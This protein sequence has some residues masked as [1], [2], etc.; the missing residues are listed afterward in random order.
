MA[1]GG[2]VPRL[3]RRHPNL[4]ADTSAGSGNNALTRDPAFA[5]EF[6][7]EFQDKLMF[8]TDSCKRSDVDR[9]WPTVATLRDLRA[10]RKLRTEALEKIE[11]RNAAR[12]LH[13]KQEKERQ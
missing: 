10:N 1:R 9:V 12:L 7:D 3:M 6:L 11:W 13:L 8:G 4:W 5:L 2:A